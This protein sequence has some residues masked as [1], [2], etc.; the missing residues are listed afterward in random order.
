MVCV[1]F[2]YIIIEVIDISLT[3]KA[4]LS[5]KVHFSPFFFLKLYQFGWNGCYYSHMGRNSGS[6]DLVCKKF[7]YT[8]VKL[9]ILLF[10]IWFVM[11]HPLCA[12]HLS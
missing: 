1:I 6:P 11:V 5:R 9:A 4:C 3:Y 8:V 7:K 2:I 12:G 10:R